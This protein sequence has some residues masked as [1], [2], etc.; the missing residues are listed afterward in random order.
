MRSAIADDVPDIVALSAV[1]RRTLKGLHPIFWKPHEDA[2]SR[3]G[4]WM[5][6]SLTF[7][8]RDMF[9]SES[10]GKLQGYA[11]SQPATPLHFPSRTTSRAIGVIDDYFHEEL[12]NAEGS[13]S[14]SDK[15]V[16]LLEAAEAAAQDEK[17]VS[18]GRL[19][20]FLAFQ[21]SLCWNGRDTQEGNHLVH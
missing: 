1:N 16:A 8:D 6:R 21:R 13:S 17:Y 20:R 2:D 4:S 19:S 11:I 10:D 7:G 18:H 14:G 3:F 15:A 5:K 9:V 12:E